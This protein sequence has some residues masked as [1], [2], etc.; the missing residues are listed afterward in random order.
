MGI[1][2]QFPKEIQLNFLNLRKTSGWHNNCGLHCLTHV[3]A[4]KLESGEL[5]HQFAEDPA[6]QA[7]LTSFQ[8]YYGLR[9]CPTW[10]EIKSLLARYVVPTDREAILGPVLRKHLGKILLQHKEILWDTLGSSALSD[11]LQ[12]G[13]VND[14]AIPIARS[15]QRFF[16]HIKAKYE[17][18]MSELELQSTTPDELAAATASLAKKKPPVE[19]TEINLQEQILFMRQQAAEAGLQPEAKA[20]WLREGCERYARQMGALNQSEMV[21]A[22]ELDLL[23]KTLH[24]GLE[25]YTHRSINKAIKNPDL[26]QKTHG[27]QHLPDFKYTWLMRVYNRGVHWEVEAAESTQAEQHNQY[28]PEGETQVEERILGRFKILESAGIGSENTI[29]EEIKIEMELKKTSAAVKKPHFEVKPLRELAEMALNKLID[30]LAVW[31]EKGEISEVDQ[32]RIF[33][34]Y[35]DQLQRA[36]QKSPDKSDKVHEITQ[37]LHSG[38]LKE[39]KEGSLL[40]E[41]SFKP[42]RPKP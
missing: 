5:Q 17:E 28:Y 15:N 40:E 41:F 14:V 34:S 24:I 18:K 4:E 38:N 32:A 35:F 20:Y 30:D 25:V 37:R 42:S 27:A 9:H 21:S 29:A 3:L 22:D 39:I 7:L 12:T 8:E 33:E 23:A 36:L 26:M 1:G 31:V 6:Y 2:R 16:G 19:A 10:D 13:K 11:Y